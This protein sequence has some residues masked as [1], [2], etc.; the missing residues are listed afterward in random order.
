MERGPLVSRLIEILVHFVPTLKNQAEAF[1]SDYNAQRTLLRGLMNMHSVKDQLPDEFFSLQD[2]LLS[3][4]LSD[5]KLVT[6][7]DTEKSKISPNIFLYRGDITVFKAD[8]IVNAA[9]SAL[10]GCFQAGHDCIDNCIHSAAGLQLRYECYKIV[11]DKGVKPGTATIS[12]AFNLPCRY[13]I[14][15]VGPKVGYDV[16]P[17]DKETLKSC[18]TEALKVA[19]KNKVSS[20]VFCCVATG[21]FGFPNVKAAE[22][23]VETVKTDLEAHGNDLKIVFDVFSDRD[24]KAYNVLLN[25]QEKNDNDLRPHFNINLI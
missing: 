10:L 9:N 21:V 25:P 13:V 18:Y 24:Y 3:D 8:A 12:H 2:Q 17:Q 15:V 19:R 7:N 14:H 20:I 22:I 11:G 6:I 23:A 16:T 4:E 5:K 1:S